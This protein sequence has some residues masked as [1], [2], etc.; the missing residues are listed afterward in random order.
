MASVYLLKLCIFTVSQPLPHRLL[1]HV[2][3]NE[4]ITI[5]KS[6]FRGNQFGLM[7]YV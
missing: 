6:H 3:H 4:F 1:M 7:H 5:G 2:I